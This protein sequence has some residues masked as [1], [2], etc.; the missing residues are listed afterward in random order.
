MAALIEYSQND[1]TV[2]QCISSISVQL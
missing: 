2:T 1:V